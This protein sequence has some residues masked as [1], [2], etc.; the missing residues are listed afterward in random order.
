[1]KWYSQ[2]ELEYAVEQARLQSYQ[3]WYELGR[4]HSQYIKDATLEIPF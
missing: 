4:R 2:E 3:E 1:M